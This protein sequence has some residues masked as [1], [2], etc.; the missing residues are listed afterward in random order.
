[1]NVFVAIMLVFAAIGFI[2]KIIGGRMGLSEYFD[3]GMLTMGT[4]AIPIVG[5]CSVG[6]EFIRRHTETIAQWSGS[7]FFDPSVIIGALLAPD[8]GGYFIAREITDSPQILLLNGV[9]LATVLGQAVTFQLPV[10]MAGIEAK[11]RQD[12]FRGFIVG[13]IMVPT[14]LIASELMIRMPLVLFLK[15]AGPVICICL[16][17][18][19]GLKVAPHGTA[20]VFSVFGVILQTLLSLLFAVAVIGVFIPSLAYASLESVQEGV[21]IIFR[22]GVIIGGALVMSEIILRFFRRQ[23]NAIAAKIGINEVAALSL[24]MT[25]ATSLAII[26]LFS[27]MDP[28]GRQITAAFSLSGSFVIGGSLAFVSSVTDGFSV[29]AFVVSKLVC[30]IASAIVIGRMYSKGSD[31]HNMKSTHTE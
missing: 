17:I 10:F 28:K 30:G 16:I 9:V 20:R 24:L 31:E 14:G 23:I 13:F 22:A 11:D 8:M 18:A 27:K 2:D 3:R 7:L 12:M 1:M 6:T 4:M 25:C 26:P 21:M 5:V 15:Q 29:A 19:I